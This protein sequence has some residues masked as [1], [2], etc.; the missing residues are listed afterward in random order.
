MAL[1]MA[2]PSLFEGFG[3]PVIE[4]MQLGTP[5]LTSNVSSLPEAGGPAAVLVEP[6][7]VDDIAAGLEKIITDKGLRDNMIRRG[8]VHASQFT[9]DR[10]ARETL[11]VYRRF[12]R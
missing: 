7:Q 5:V 11:S 1:V 9:G 2:Y 6:D 4:A 8:F 12:G 10:M 3:Y